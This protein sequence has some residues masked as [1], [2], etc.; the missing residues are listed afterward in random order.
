MASASSFSFIPQ[1]TDDVFISFRGEDTRHTFTAHLLAAFYRLKIRTYVD[2]KLGRGDE[3]SPTLIR[4]I[5][6]SKV[7][8]IVLSKNYATSKWCLE[9]LVKIMECRRTKGQIAI[10]VFYHVDP[11]DVR[12]Q[13]GSY[14]DAFANH[15]QR[16]KD[17]VQKV[18]LWRASLREVTNLSGW[19]C[20]VNRTESQLVEDA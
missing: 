12:N 15:E 9:E 19:D 2:Y 3:I 4:A 6:E 11:S 20:L 1:E 13:T 10:P 17:N 18:E 14:A 5:E 7:S 8:V 16:F